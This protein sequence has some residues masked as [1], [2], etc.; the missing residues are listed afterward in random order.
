MRPHGKRFLREAEITARLQHPGIV[1][2]Y[3]LGEDDDGPFYTMPL[4]EGQTLQEAIEEF[5]GDAIP[6]SATRAGGACGSAELLQQFIDGLQH[7]GLRPRP[8][9]GAPRPEAVEHHAR[10]LRR[11]PGDGLG[12]GQAVRRGAI[13]T[14]SRRGTAPSPSPSSGRLDGHRRGSGH[15]SVH[16]PRASQWPPD[17]ARQRHLQPRPDPVRDPD[18]EPGFRGSQPGGGDPLKAVRDATVLPP[19]DRDPHLP[20]RSTRS[21]SRPSRL[22]P[23]DRGTLRRVTWPETSNWLARWTRHRLPQAMAGAAGGLVPS[24]LGRGSRRGWP[25]AFSW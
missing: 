3:G 18:R 2:I 1:P 8:G 16:E 19:R 10:P 7:R 24:T 14:T 13:R 9:R 20:R 12:P 11:D 17:R 5:H 15:A 4:I 6:P 25:P 22:D 21:V 23:E